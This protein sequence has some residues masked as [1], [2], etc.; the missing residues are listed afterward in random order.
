MQCFWFLTELAFAHCRRSENGLCLKRLHSV[1]KIFNDIHDDQFDFHSYCLRKCTIRS[2]MAMIEFED[3]LKNHAYY[4][5]AALGAVQMYFDLADKPE[6]ALA[7]LNPKGNWKASEGSEK[8]KNKKKKQ[9][10]EAN[11][12]KKIVV[13]EDPKGLAL[14]DGSNVDF[15][16]EALKFCNVLQDYKV[17]GREG[18]E[19]WVFSAEIHLRN[20]KRIVF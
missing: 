8:R 17:M 10:M 4:V 7:E 6:G 18:I 19:A 12:A 11:A 1:D 2:Y 13:D 3:G 20:G 14:V 15:L 16:K 5:K 9:E